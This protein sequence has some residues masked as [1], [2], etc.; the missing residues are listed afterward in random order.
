MTLYYVSSLSSAFIFRESRYLD[1]RTY[2]SNASSFISVHASDI[3]IAT[4]KID[5]LK[6]WLHTNKQRCS[7]IVHNYCY[8]ITI[9]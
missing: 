2:I 6:Q 8:S 5:Q 7:I 4:N 1:L 3:H 9:T